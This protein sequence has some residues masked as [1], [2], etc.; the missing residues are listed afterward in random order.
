MDWLKIFSKSLGSTIGIM[1]VFPILQLVMKYFGVVWP[2]PLPP[3]T[4]R[5]SYWG[6]PWGYVTRTVDI[7]APY[8]IDWSYLIYDLI[9]WFLISFVYYSLKARTTSP[10]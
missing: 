6:V 8:V 9:F 7:E 3:S 1:I 4:P 2:A 5:T 10:T